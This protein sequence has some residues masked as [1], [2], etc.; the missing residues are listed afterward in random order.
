[1]S[2]PDVVLAA[3]FGADWEEWADAL[4]RRG[5]LVWRAR[6]LEEA[7]AEVARVAP[8]LLVV[9]QWLSGGDGAEL[10][11]FVRSRPELGDTRIVLVGDHEGAGPAPDRA[12]GKPVELPTLLDAI[13]RLGPPAAPARPPAP[14]PAARDEPVAPPAL[15]GG[16]PFPGLPAEGDQFRMLAQ[17]W[18]VL[19]RLGD[20]LRTDTLTGLLDREYFLGRLREEFRK[21]ERYRQPISALMLDVDDF[22][23]VNDAHG[24]DAGNE[25]L[26]GI[27]AAIRDEIRREIDVAARLHGDEFAILL[28]NTGTDG[29]VAFAERLRER[30]RRDGALAFPATVSLGIA[31]SQPDYRD[32]ESGLLARADRA[33][34][35]GK[36]IAKDRISVSGPPTAPPAPSASS[37]PPPPPP[38]PVLELPSGPAGNG[39]AAHASASPAPAPAPPLPPAPAPAAPPVAPRPPEKKSAVLTP[40]VDCVLLVSEEREVAELLSGFLAKKGIPVE[41][42]RSL[43]DA[44]RQLGSGRF[45][46]AMADGDRNPAAAAAFAAAAGDIDPDLGLFLFSKDGARPGALK[47][48]GPFRKMERG[49]K[50]AAGGKA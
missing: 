21:A 2:M 25:V 48:A 20:L 50:D 12:L 36:K 26:K 29:A 17:L 42:A 14:A 22:K 5:F 13:D 15:P 7:E 28:P 16:F 1:M 9:D 44:R 11:R 32:G 19:R 49:L 18:D 35:D 3:S 10:V 45:F 27:G 30:L 46:L 37:A 40:S 43:D 6:T 34:L 41:T 8:G 33:L 38:A 39:E 47:K 24:H 4:R 31:T 23:S